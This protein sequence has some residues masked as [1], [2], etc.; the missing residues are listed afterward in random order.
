MNILKTQLNVSSTMLENHDRLQ[1]I[2]NKHNILVNNMRTQNQ[3]NKLKMEDELNYYKVR[4]F[5]FLN[6]FVYILFNNFS[7]EK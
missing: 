5:L 2:C 7:V 4:V 1:A 6:L 3:I